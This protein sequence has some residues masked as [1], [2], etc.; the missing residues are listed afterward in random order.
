MN[1]S[2]LRRMFDDINPMTGKLRFSYL[3]CMT[4]ASFYVFP[5]FS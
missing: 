5:S 2:E 4:L 3:H 1:N